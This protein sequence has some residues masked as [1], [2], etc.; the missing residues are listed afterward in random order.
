[1]FDSSME[2]IE[3]EQAELKL[4]SILLKRK[5]THLY[6]AEWS[7]EPRTCLIQHVC[8]SVCAKKRNHISVRSVFLNWRA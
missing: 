3:L 5:Y 4:F 1:M 8:T 2:N 7:N 6:L